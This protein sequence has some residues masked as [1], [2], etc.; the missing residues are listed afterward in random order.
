MWH[1]NHRTHKR[2]RRVCAHDTRPV[3][4]KWATETAEEKWRIKWARMICDALFADGSE[5]NKM[6][7]SQARC[8]CCWI[9]NLNV[10]HIINYIVSTRTVHSCT[11]KCLEFRCPV[12]WLFLYFSQTC[13]RKWQLALAHERNG[14][15]LN[16]F[17][18]F[19]WLVA[20]CAGRSSHE[21]TE[22]NA[23]C[24][25]ENNTKKNRS[26]KSQENQNGSKPPNKHKTVVP[27]ALHG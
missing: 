4:L 17:F 11:V 9:G 2:I 27:G 16:I 23:H 1:R 15:K 8:S 25:G 7:D 6:N 18:P 5:K 24:K 22:V 12:L 14:R 13:N 3:H 19:R 26:R 20:C 10:I 21:T